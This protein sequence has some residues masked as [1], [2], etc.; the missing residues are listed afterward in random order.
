V[1]KAFKLSSN[2]KWQSAEVEAYTLALDRLHHP[3]TATI[4]GGVVYALNSKFNE[5]TDPTTPPSKEFSLQQVR[6]VPAK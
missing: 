1:N 5:I 3:T 2:D 4:S 6:F